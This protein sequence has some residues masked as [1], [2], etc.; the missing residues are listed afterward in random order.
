MVTR[1][2]LINKISELTFDYDKCGVCNGVVHRLETRC[3][4]CA[5]KRNKKFMGV[6]FSSFF[7][8]LVLM[9]VFFVAGTCSLSLFVIIPTAISFAYFLS[10]KFKER[11]LKRYMC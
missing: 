9:M 3:R 7:I 11:W 6:Y 2:E 10:R 5:S 1:H 8:L 4:W